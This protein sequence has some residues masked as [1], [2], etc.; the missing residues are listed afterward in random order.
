[1][2]FVVIL[3]VFL[4]NAI[5]GLSVFFTGDLSENVDILDILALRFL[6]SFAVLFLLKITGIIRVRVGVRDI[7]R[8]TEHSAQIRPLL[9]TGLFEPVLYMLLETAGIAMTTGITAAVILSLS[10]IFSCICEAI[11]LKESNTLTQKLL[12]GIGIV[13]VI[14]IAVHTNTDT[15]K[16]SIQGIVFMFL[17]VV[18]GALFAT[19]SRKV[20]KHFRPFEVSYIACLLGTVAFNALNLGKHLIAGT[21]PHYF[22]PILQPRNL[23]AFA[24]LG[25]FST[26]V[27]A[28]M[29]NY[30]LS[31]SR[32][33]SLAAFS[34]VSTLV[35]IAADVLWNGETLYPFHFIGITLIFIR[36]IGVTWI[37]IK[38]NRL[39]VSASK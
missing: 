17:A 25:I 23:V 3:F 1:M 7:F 37:D 27:A 11:F 38:N 4:K 34:G 24:Y 29:N 19:F 14:Y 30:A 16:D 13:G 10:P 2:S 35:T 36:M 32:V 15:G 39:G 26:I 12:L 9:L 21:L 8:K 33:S 22:D 31:K 18:C 28:S 20:S 5:Y 6:I